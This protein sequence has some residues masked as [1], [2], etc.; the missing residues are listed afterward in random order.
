MLVRGEEVAGNGSR[1]GQLSK[2]SLREGHPTIQLNR[3]FFL[4]ASDPRKRPQKRPKP[5]AGRLLPQLTTASSMLLSYSSVATT[6]MLAAMILERLLSAATAPLLDASAIAC[7][8]C[9][10]RLSPAA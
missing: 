10:R 5:P 7:D 6:S 3:L 1:L 9:L 2:R 4:R 8:A